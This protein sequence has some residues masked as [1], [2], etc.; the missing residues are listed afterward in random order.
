MVVSTVRWWVVCFSSSNSDV[1][2]KPCSEQPCTTATPQKEEGLNQ[3]IH[4]NRLPVV[5]VLKNSVFVVEKWLCQVV[6]LCSLYLL[7]FPWK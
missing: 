2:D 5:T 1:K 4:V 3:F 6:L 7:Q